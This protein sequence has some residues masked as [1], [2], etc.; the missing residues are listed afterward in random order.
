MPCLTGHLTLAAY[1]QVRRGIRA[2]AGHPEG[3]GS[4]ARGPT[5]T[6]GSRPTQHPESRDGAG[7]VQRCAN[8][9]G[10]GTV[11]RCVGTPVRRCAGASPA[12]CAAPA[13][14]PGRR[15]KANAAGSARS[16][17]G[18]GEGTISQLV[19][20]RGRGQATSGQANA[21]T[22][23]SL[24]STATEPSHSSAR[25][26]YVWHPHRVAAVS[27]WPLSGASGTPFLQGL[28]MPPRAGARTR[29][30]ARQ[31]RGAAG[32]AR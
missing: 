20:A 5:S 29:A 12:A 28:T 7:T 17:P 11:Q 24:A 16:M 19:E 18:Q 30:A 23:A 6:T 10:A 1:T 15:L 26:V 31:L 9:S 25:A 8:C 21:P 32:L 22:A 13:T 27:P 14:L 2:G 3:R 4:K